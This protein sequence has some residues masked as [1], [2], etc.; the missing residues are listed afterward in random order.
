MEA[1]SVT[2]PFVAA[3]N[4][5]LDM[6]LGRDR[7]PRRGI[8]ELGCCSAATCSSPALLNG[9]LLVLMVWLFHTRWRVAD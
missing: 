4:V 5:P 9:L 6:D 7:G 8:T 1:A 2:S 3:F